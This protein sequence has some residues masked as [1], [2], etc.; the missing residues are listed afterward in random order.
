MLKSLESKRNWIT[1]ML[2]IGVI[3]VSLY[4]FLGA[5]I[6]P[7]RGFAVAQ[8]DT[9]LYL[10]AARRIAE[11]F[12][13]TYSAGG[14]VNT[15][16]TSVIYPFLL[17]PMYLLGATGGALVR[18]GFALNAAFYLVFLFFWGETIATKVE[19]RFARLVAAGVIALFGQFAFVALAQSDIG[20]W[21]AFSS[22]IVFALATERERLA[23]ALLFVAPW[24]RPEG[25]VFA[26]A[27]LAVTRKARS[28]IP[29]V[30]VAGL[31]A[32]NAVLTGSLQFNSL[33]GKGHLASEPF[34]A[35]ISMIARDALTMARTLFLGGPSGTFRE[36]LFL[37]VLGAFFLWYHVFTRDYSKF[38]A[39]E[40]VVLLAAA[41]GFATVAASGMQGTNF[42][43]YLAWMMPL[44]VV[45]MA[46]GAIAFGE[47]FRGFG[48]ALPAALLVAFTFAGAIAT[49]ANFRMASEESESV[50]SFYARCESRMLNHVGVA[51]FGN[52]GAVYE[53]GD[54]PFLH[55][56]GIYSP[57]FKSRNLLSAF[58]KLKHERENR[59]WYWLYADD[60]EGRIVGK[61]A[62]A[63]YGKTVLAGPAGLELRQIDWRPFDRALAE[64]SVKR[65]DWILRD[66]VDV[67]FDADERRAGYESFG[68]FL[69]RPQLAFVAFEDLG[70]EKAAEVGRVALGGDEMTVSGLEPGKDAFVVMR[71]MRAH[72]AVSQGASART[73]SDFRFNSPLE[74]HV[75][76]DGETAAHVTGEVD[77]DGF[78]DVVFRI[79]G[80]AIKN[81]T[82]RIGFDG[83]HI[84]FAY[85]FYQ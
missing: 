73:A 49:A 36:F 13:F 6:R 79:P 43:R 51:S 2:V 59:P 30:S 22:A 53:F 74:L 19:N 7:D 24:V 75:D 16:T 47:R 17:A 3:Q 26:I 21:L 83:G 48:R 69:M 66:S 10:Q 28:L 71:T 34:C 82:S 60:V 57:E 4:Y 72:G 9:A 40:G 50:R 52:S 25:I 12:P 44:A 41:G 35:A 58:E 32:F 33:Q 18:A 68:D 31:F 65:A 63:I 61:E 15:G 54:R 8:P 46:E 38:R 14:S 84:A 62:L 45:Y 78:T 29:L 42:D 81:S 70:G 11:G 64:P 55:L 56:Y 5:T 20:L 1:L 27:Y 23:L 85:W 37:P 76:V 67:G 80:S 39:G 77:E